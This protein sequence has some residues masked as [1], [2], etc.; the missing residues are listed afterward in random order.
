[1]CRDFQFGRCNRGDSCRFSHGD[2]G[3]GGG[4][5]G[6]SERPAAAAGACFDFIKGRCFRRDCKF[7][8]DDT[9]PIEVIPLD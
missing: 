6:R 9:A 8:H 4:G 7:V 2:A 5:G 1:M 3:R